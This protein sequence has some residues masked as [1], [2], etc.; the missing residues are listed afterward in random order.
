VSD[1][2]PR[3][4]GVRDSASF[5]PELEA[6]RGWAIGLVFLFHADG[7]ITGYERI[8]TT[9]SPALAFITAGHTGVTLFFVLS[10]FLLSRPFLEEG[11]GGRVVGRPNFF[12]R[13]ILRIMPLYS[14]AVCVAVALAWRNPT[15]LVDGLAAL[16]FL[17]SFT[18]S[19]ASLIP[20][21]AV[22]WS[23]A[24]E[25]QFYLVL[26]LLGLCLRS[27]TGRRLGLAALLCWAGA[28]I[29]I[30]TQPG[31]LSNDVHFRLSLSLFGRAH[32]FLAG[33]AA[34]WLVAR[35][36]ER[37]RASA[38]RTPWL[39]NGGADVL[40]ILV[41]FGLGMVL[42]QVTYRG[43]VQTEISA[44]LSHLAESLLWTIVLLIVLLA[45]LKIRHLITNR[46]F[47]TLGLLS[48]SLYLI[49]EPI[50]FFGLSQLVP[51][52]IPVDVNLSLRAAAFAIAFVLCLA[53]SAI[54]YRVIERPFLVRKANINL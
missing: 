50:L 38:L 6:L 27:K 39:R 2:N 42:Q 10:A 5:S 30:A 49:H 11:R 17:N 29:I 1:P 43:F 36:G 16:F 35:H 34:S 9:V 20:Y 18:G 3:P 15:A 53:L 51:R 48:Y 7:V 14:V 32:A 45:P 22:W 4:A 47:T 31:L 21:S 8:G 41:L 46:I 44:P 26:P 28:S 40:L 12:R 33:I 52:G 25:V 24:T 23:L 19:V 54:S 13:R 37:I